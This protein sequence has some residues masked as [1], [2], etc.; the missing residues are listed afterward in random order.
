V[1]SRLAVAGDLR[2]HRLVEVAV[3][4]VDL[5]RRLRAVWLGGAQLPA[6]P[7]RHLVAVAA[8]PR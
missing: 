7:A 3:R 4:G 1:L 5:D 8:G 6:G 2:E